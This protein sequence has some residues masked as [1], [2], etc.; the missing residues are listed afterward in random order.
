M[1][2]KRGGRGVIMKE[3]EG[4]R[5]ER[6]MEFCFPAL[7]PPSFGRSEVNGKEGTI[8]WK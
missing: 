8:Q 5:K 1:D 7:F 3:G 2:D 6:E 4:E